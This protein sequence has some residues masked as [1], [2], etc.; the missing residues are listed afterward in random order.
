MSDEQQPDSGRR[1]F[2]K[3]CIGGLAVASAGMVGFPIVSFMAGA[4]QAGGNKPLEVPMDRLS[5]GQ[6]QYVEFR[7]QQLI[8]L[9]GADG[10]HVFSASCP[11]LGCNVMWDSGDTLFRC[12]CHGAMFNGQ[13]KVVKGPV[14]ASLT[15]IPFEIK[16]GKII[17]S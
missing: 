15:S 10:P 4:E 16:D 8:V 13:G 11:H 14:S 1:T 7:G 9:N 17:I 5:P 6:A 12:P 2:C 3:V